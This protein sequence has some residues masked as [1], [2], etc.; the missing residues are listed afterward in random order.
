MSKGVSSVVSILEGSWGYSIRTVSQAA[1]KFRHGCRLSCCDGYGL[2]ISTVNL[3]D[4]PRWKKSLP[5]PPLRVCC[6]KPAF[7]IHLVSVSRLQEPDGFRI[8]LAALRHYSCE[9]L[10]LITS[11]AAVR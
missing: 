7:S 5:S 11:F 3:A 6:C 10:A 4:E 9:G 2:R 1:T 8:P